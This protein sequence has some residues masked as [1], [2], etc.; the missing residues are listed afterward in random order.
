[1]AIRDSQKCKTA[2][3]SHCQIIVPIHVKHGIERIDGN[4]QGNKVRCKRSECKLFKKQ[5]ITHSNRNVNGSRGWAFTSFRRCGARAS[6]S[7]SILYTHAGMSANQ[8]HWRVAQA[9]TSIHYNLKPCVQWKSKLHQA[10]VLTEYTDVW[11]KLTGPFITFLNYVCSEKVHYTC[12]SSNA[13]SSSGT[14]FSDNVLFISSSCVSGKGGLQSQGSKGRSQCTGGTP[15]LS[16]CNQFFTVHSSWS[17]G[18]THV[19]MHATLCLCVSGIQCCV[20][21]LCQVNTKKNACMTVCVDK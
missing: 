14:P 5:Q 8:M 9:H 15:L 4:L 1:M 16:C 20:A 13:V 11:P 12:K 19:T 6:K 21:Y 10:W 17:Q 7:W 18:T 2:S 3:S